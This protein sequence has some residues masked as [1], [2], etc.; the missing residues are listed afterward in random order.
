MGYDNSSNLTSP[1][2]SVCTAQGPMT[3]IFIF[4]VFEKYVVAVV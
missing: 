3:G 1:Y 4:Q 2:F